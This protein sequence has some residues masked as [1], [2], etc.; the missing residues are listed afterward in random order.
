VLVFPPVNKIHISPDHVTLIIYEPLYVG[1]HPDLEQFFADLEYKNRVLFLS[2]SRNMMS[3]LLESAKKQLAIRTAKAELI[4]DG[5][6][7]D[8]P[9]MES[10]NNLYENALKAMN[11][12]AKETFTSLSYPINQD[13]SSVIKSNNE[14]SMIFEHNKY[15]GE[16]QIRAELLNRKKFENIDKPDDAFR[17]KCEQRI[18]TQKVMPWSDVKNRAAT[19]AHWP[20]YHPALLDNLKE[21][22]VTKDYGS[23]TGEATLEII[24]VHGDKVYY[25]YNTP[26]TTGSSQ[27][28]DLKSFKTSAMCIYFLC[29]DSKGEHKPGD[30]T[31]WNN[32][33]TLK[34]NI[35][36][37]EFEKTVELATAPTGARIKYTTDGSDPLQHGAVYEG[38]FT[39]DRSV[40]H[41]VAIAE[42][43][44]I[45]SNQIKEEQHGAL[46]DGPFTIDHSVSHVVAIAESNGILSNQIKE[47]QHGAMY[48]GPFTIDHSV[49]HVVAIAESNGILSNQI[50]EDINWNSGDRTD[51]GEIPIDRP[52]IWKHPHKNPTTNESYTFIEELRKHDAKAQAVIIEI[53]SSVWSNLSVCKD[54]S[55]N[56]TQ[57]ET[58]IEALK[59]IGID[60]DVS[61][62]CEQLAFETGQGLLDFANFKK[63]NV[64]SEEVTQ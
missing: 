13:G 60:G 9:Q 61:L 11:G 26:A 3:S 12:I 29:V 10:A 20:W 36:G 32:E 49:S 58:L 31:V 55:L 44:G 16:I 45:L 62:A 15:D 57:L 8:D 25:E 28:E 34:S 14:F 4:Q 21:D 64:R 63:M 5:V 18:F 30:Q 47:E 56:P 23:N 59:C 52:V 51:G 50:I 22:L 2:G 35:Y 33:I 41:V 43:N 39:I 27:V 1:L 7:S 19:N 37:N 24:P 38:P 40:S 42:S 46:Y 17:K 48:N 6:R 53:G 54:I